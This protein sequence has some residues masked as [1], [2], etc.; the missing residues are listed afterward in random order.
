MDSADQAQLLEE[1][2]RQQS[3]AARSTHAAREARIAASF[4]PA[5]PSIEKLCIDCDEPIES[6]RLEALR[7]CTSRCIQCARIYEQN[8]DQ[9]R[10]R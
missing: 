10:A 4:E 6:E 9:R 8:E 7:G 3:I 5:D 2:E 1:R